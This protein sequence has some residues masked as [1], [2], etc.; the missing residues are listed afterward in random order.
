MIPLRALYNQTPAAGLAADS[1][2]PKLGP[3][4]EPDLVRQMLRAE[5]HGKL[6]AH[7]QLSRDRRIGLASQGGYDEVRA[8]TMSR[9]GPGSLNGQA[10]LKMGNLRGTKTWQ[11]PTRS[12]NLR[13]TLQ[14]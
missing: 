3:S 7:L 4:H 10:P 11:A 5:E 8:Q 12:T 9:V 6:T 13:G 2:F 1:S 14:R